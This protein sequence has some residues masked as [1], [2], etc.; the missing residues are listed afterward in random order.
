[1]TYGPERSRAPWSALPSL[2]AQPALWPIAARLA[3][4]LVAPSWWRRWPFLPHVPAD[5]L[6]MRNETMFGSAR[7]RLSGDELIAYLQWCRR[8]DDLAR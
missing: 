5:Y 7:G 8:M 2:V 4:S 6:R 1:M 3:R